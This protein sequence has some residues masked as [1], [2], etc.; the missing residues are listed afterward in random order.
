MAQDVWSSLLLPL[1]MG[2][3]DFYLSSYTLFHMRGF[4][5]LLSSL[6]VGGDSGTRGWES[7]CLHYPNSAHSHIQKQ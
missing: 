5:Y 6:I 2:T 1:I 7:G 4:P 3:K